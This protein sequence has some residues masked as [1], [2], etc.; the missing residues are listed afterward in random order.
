MVIA[1]GAAASTREKG[2]KGDDVVRGLAVGLAGM[3]ALIFAT[4]RP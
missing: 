2:P 4:S 1:V 3:V